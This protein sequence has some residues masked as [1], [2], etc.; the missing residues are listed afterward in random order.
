MKIDNNREISRTYKK[1]SDKSAKSAV[2]FD[3]FLSSIEDIREE[4][5]LEELPKFLPISFDSSHEE[6][7]KDEGEKILSSLDNLKLEILSGRISKENLSNI[8]TLI[9]DE[10]FKSSDPKLQNILQEI[11]TRAAV[12]LAKLEAVEK[13]IGG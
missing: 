4:I 6:R 5:L 10:S 3:S 7:L 9:R 8:S 11:Q 13:N 12:E 1:S 2:S